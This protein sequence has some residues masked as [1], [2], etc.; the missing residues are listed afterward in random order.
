MYVCA[1]SILFDLD[2]GRH[3]YSAVRFQFRYIYI[4]DIYALAIGVF[5]IPFDFQNRKLSLRCIIPGASARLIY[6][7][8]NTVSSN[9]RCTLTIWG[10]NSFKNDFSLPSETVFRS[11]CGAKSRP[12]L[13]K[14]SICALDLYFAPSLPRGF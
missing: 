8:T 9:V 10:K 12:R 6:Y 2:H 4:Y 7:I 13:N 1:N 14:P 11:K 5:K 3:N